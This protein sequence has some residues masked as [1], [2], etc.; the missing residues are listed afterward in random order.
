MQQSE[1]GMR[2]HGLVGIEIGAEA[3]DFEL[4]N[5]FGEP[6]RLSSYRG[7]SAVALVFFPLAFSSTCTGEFEELRDNAALFSEAGVE[8]LGISV[9]SKHTLRA[10][11]AAERFAMPLL[12]D[13]WPH[14]RVAQLYGAFREEAG[15]SSRTTVFVDREGAVRSVFSSAPGEARAFSLYRSA[16]AELADEER[17]GGQTIAE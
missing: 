16:L 1:H 5:Q 13:F 4:V 8:L 11:W 15:V 9:D 2:D 3:P 10:W 12:A 6:V 7:R 14:G 17:P